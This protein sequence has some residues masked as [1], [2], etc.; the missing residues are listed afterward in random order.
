[1]LDFEKMAAI[2]ERAEHPVAVMSNPQ[3]SD[4]EIVVI[5]ITAE[6]QADISARGLECR[7]IAGVI[8]GAPEIEMPRA[9]SEDEAFAIGAAYKRHIETRTSSPIAD[10]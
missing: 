4:F 3:R 7:A 5:P 2:I 1:M 10:A 8:Q 9:L 6:V